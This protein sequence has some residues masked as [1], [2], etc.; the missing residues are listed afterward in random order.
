MC[1]GVGVG[2]GID[3]CIGWIIGVGVRIG[4]PVRRHA[5]MHERR[6]GVMALV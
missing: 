2:E 3:I 6:V 1:A 5:Y 4:G